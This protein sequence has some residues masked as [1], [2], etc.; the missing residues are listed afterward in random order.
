MKFKRIRDYIKPIKTGA[1][2]TIGYKVIKNKTYHSKRYNKDID[3]KTTDKPYD[4]A[5][6]AKDV[7]SLAWP[8]HDVLCREGCFSDGSE[9]NNWQAS[10]VISDIL[11]DDG[12]WFRARLWFAGTWL[13]GG[14]KAR[15]NGML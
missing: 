14:N 1:G 5:T 9:C 15:K 3:I 7:D 8:M 13:I 10:R 2:V 6:W 11:K 12:Y 4:G